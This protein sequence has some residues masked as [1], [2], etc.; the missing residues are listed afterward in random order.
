MNSNMVLWL[1]TCFLSSAL[2]QG[3]NGF[4]YFDSWS[5]SIITGDNQLFLSRNINLPWPSFRI[6]SIKVR[7]KHLCV[8]VNGFSLIRKKMLCEVDQRTAKLLIVCMS[9]TSRADMWSCNNVIIQ[10]RCP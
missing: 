3:L 9:V 6:R 10:S 4:F 2:N 7:R 1:N 8:N 5:P